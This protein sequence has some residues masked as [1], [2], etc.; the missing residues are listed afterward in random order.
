MEALVNHIKHS[1]LRG[2]NTLHVVG[3][4]FNPLRFHS[5]YRLFKKWQKEML[6]TPHVKLYIVEVAYN[7]QHFEVTDACNPQHLQLKTKQEIWLKESAINLAVRYLLPRDWSHVAWIDCDVSFQ[8]KHWAQAA[9]HELQHRP[10]IQPWSD[11]IDLGPHGQV[12]DHW[13]GFCYVHRKGVPKQ[14]NLRHPYVFAHPGYAWCCTRFFWEQTNGLMPFCL[15]GSADHH[16]SW[17]LIAQ[18]E[19]TYP[20]AMSESYKA[21]VTDWQAGALHA[22]A[23]DNIGYIPGLITHHFHGKKKNRK[24]RERWDILISNQYDPDH[25]LAYDSR[26]LIQLVGKPRLKHDI[27]KYFRQRC[28]DSLDID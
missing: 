22:T 26:G 13:Q 14:V 20:K 9:L 17:S 8:N 2:D 25:D 27:M 23:G 4:I 15:L 16:M 28:E 3:V 12:L 21:R 1:E 7:H 5:R 11:A 10:I 18:S 24:Y 19:T 6:E